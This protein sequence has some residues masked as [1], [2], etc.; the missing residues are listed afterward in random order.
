MW[1]IVMRKCIGVSG[2]GCGCMVICCLKMM[3]DNFLFLVVWMIC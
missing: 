2:L 1:L 3:M